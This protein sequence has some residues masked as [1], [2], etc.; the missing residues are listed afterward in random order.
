[1]PVAGTP[2]YSVES[3]PSR[4]S[5]WG[6]VSHIQATLEGSPG[7]PLPFVP[8]LLEFSSLS[9]CLFHF[10]FLF[11]LAFQPIFLLIFLLFFTSLPSPLQI[12]H[13]LWFNLLFLFTAS[14]PFPS[15]FG[16]ALFGTSSVPGASRC[17]LSPRPGSVQGMGPGTPPP[18][19]WGACL[20]DM[21]REHLGEQLVCA[22]VGGVVECLFFVKTQVGLLPP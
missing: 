16:T 11:L 8:F 22:G 3:P 14:C 17:F 2:L 21:L 13:F 4:L 20:T 15:C 6:A 12:S 9:P 5:W 1:M 10:C 18:L 7:S 19:A